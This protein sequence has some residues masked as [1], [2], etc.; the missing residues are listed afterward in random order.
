MFQ[1]KLEDVTI[2]EGKCHVV[3]NPENTQELEYR[4]YYFDVELTLT[5][6][7]K[8]TKLYKFKLTPETT[9]YGGD[10]NGN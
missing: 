2:E 9:I 1:K 10:S 8:K 6:G 4:E 5:N 3:F 7:T